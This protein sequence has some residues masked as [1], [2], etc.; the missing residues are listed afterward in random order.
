MMM[1]TPHSRAELNAQHLTGRTRGRIGW[2]GRIIMQVEV[3]SPVPRFP[4]APP[5]PEEPYDPWECGAYY[6]WRD[7]TAQDI[8]KVNECGTE[9]AEIC[10][11]LEQVGAK[12]S[13]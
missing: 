12:I 4:S 5:P 8:I 2:F 11:L 13:A 1:P 6:F 7:A 9:A 3:K 10:R